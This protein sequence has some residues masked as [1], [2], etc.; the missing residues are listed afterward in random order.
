MFLTLA[1]LPSKLRFSGK[2]LSTVMWMLSSHEMHT[3]WTLIF[4]ASN[5]AIRSGD[6]VLENFHHL[7]TVSKLLQKSRASKDWCTV[8]VSI[9][10]KCVSKWP[11]DHPSIISI[12]SWDFQKNWKSCIQEYFQY[13][14]ALST[15]NWNSFHSDLDY[16]GDVATVCVSAHDAEKEHFKSYDPWPTW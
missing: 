15:C 1:Y 13:I 14:I 2:Y 11:T 5:K 8:Q 12:L 7:H 6:I 3:C 9:V 4:T 10:R 16:S